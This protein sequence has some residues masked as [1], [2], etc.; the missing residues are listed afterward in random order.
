MSDV[1]S[2]V[3]G[4]TSNQSAL[5]AMPPGTP[6]SS[7]T[8]IETPSGLKR[9]RTD[10]APPVGTAVR[11]AR[12]DAT[13][14]LGDFAHPTTSSELLARASALSEVLL[15][16]RA[17][18]SEFDAFC[19]EVASASTPVHGARPAPHRARA[20]AFGPHDFHCAS[21]AHRRAR[22][23]A[24]GAGFGQQP[25]GDPATHVFVNTLAP[26][27]IAAFVKHFLIAGQVNSHDY[28]FL[29]LDSK[30]AF[31]KR[32]AFAG[33][34]SSRASFRTTPPSSP[35]TTPSTTA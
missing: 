10:G 2:P 16:H 20:A 32:K 30:A 12:E 21:R 35:R 28:Q 25:S 34:R 5:V 26:D 23:R 1:A 15:A 18:K 22:H 14:V 27:T 17:F 19:A 33:T 11:L 31:N 8:E 3:V 24:R 7:A 4:V 9:T 29:L 6:R 13:T